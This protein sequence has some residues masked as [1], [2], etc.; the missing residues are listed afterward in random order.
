M[1]KR[2]QKVARLSFNAPVILGFVLI[3]VIAYLLETFIGRTNILL[4]SVYRSSL[5]DVLTYFRFFGH[6]FGHSNLSHILNNMMMI[7]LLGPAVEERYGHG[8]TALT[9]AV[10][11]L[12][13]G[14]VNFIFFPH[15]ALLGASGV[16]FCFIIMSSAMGFKNHEIPITFILVAILYLGEQITDA[17]MVKDNVSQLTHIVGGVVGGAMAVIHRRKY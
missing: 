15:T 6:V 9:I 17:V 11:A 3:C 1:T 8:Y 5:R 14:L 4:F 16:V 10:T 2:K 7:L 13:T 12:V